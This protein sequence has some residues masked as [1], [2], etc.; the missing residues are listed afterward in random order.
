MLQFPTAILWFS[1]QDTKHCAAF[2]KDKKISRE[3]FKYHKQH[4]FRRCYDEAGTL[5][6]YQ[7]NPLSQVEIPAA[8]SQRS[9]AEVHNF[10]LQRQTDGQKANV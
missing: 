4:Q 5:L 2:V 8:P 7:P 6:R 3:S 9:S 1:R 10:T